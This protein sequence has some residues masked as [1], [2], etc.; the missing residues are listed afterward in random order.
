MLATVDIHT[1][2]QLPPV[3]G[4]PPFDRENQ[5]AVCNKVEATAGETDTSVIFYAEPV[6]ITGRLWH[7]KQL[8]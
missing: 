4:Q 5:K 7:M 8:E 6:G 2:P 1:W 3:L